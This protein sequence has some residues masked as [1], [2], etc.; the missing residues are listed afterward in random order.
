MLVLRRRYCCRGEDVGGCIILGV[1]SHGVMINGRWLLY[2]VVV[3]TRNGLEDEL[4]PPEI[5]MYEMCLF[6][7]FV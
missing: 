5:C 1:E 6:G 4:T 3:N 2:V 7:G